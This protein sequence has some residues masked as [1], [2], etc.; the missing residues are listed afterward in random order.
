MKRLLMLSLVFAFC[1]ACAACGAKTPQ[2]G[3]TPTPPV[4]DGA[5]A[6]EGGEAPAEIEQT[7]L[8]VKTLN[9][10]FA[11]TE[12][13]V[14]KLLTLQT[15]FP[16]ALT[17]ALAAQN[18]TV[19]RVNVTFGTSDTATMAALANGSIDLA[20]VSAD[21]YLAAPGGTVLGAE[22]SETPALSTGLLISG[23]ADAL[24]ARLRAAL[25]E[26]APLLSAYT[27]ETAGGVYAEDAARLEALARLYEEALEAEAAR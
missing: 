14:D 1:L 8:T 16:Q 10:E 21:S 6:A 9:V 22:Q 23:E 5:G 24:N 20:F 2:G 13:D 27:D 12:R 19:E 25:P 17:D 3:D 26:L 7:P 15:A 11:A 4:T 18:V